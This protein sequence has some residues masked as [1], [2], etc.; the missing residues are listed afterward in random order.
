VTN[1]VRKGIVDPAAFAGNPDLLVYGMLAALVSAALWLH[2]ASYFGQPVSTTHSIVGAIFG[3]GLIAGGAINWAKMTAIVASWV[4]SPLASGL[5]GFLTFVFIKKKIL[6]TERPDEAAAKYAPYLV[7][8]VTFMLSMA[9]IFKGLK[10]LHLDWP[11]TKALVVSA[12]AAIGAGVLAF[13]LLPK[14]VKREEELEPT[15][16]F[17]YTERIFKYLQITTASY[18]A[19]AHGANDVA[20]AVGPLAAVYAV[21]STGEVT[22]KVGVPIW[23]LLLGGAGIVVGLAMFGRRVMETVGHRITHMTPTR[24]FSAEFAA[25]TTVLVCSKIGLPIST[26]HSL[27]GAVMGVG[28]ARGLAAL[29]LKTILTLSDLDTAVGRGSADRRAAFSQTRSQS[30]ADASPNGDGEIHVDASVNR[31]GDQFRRV[32]FGYAKVDATVGGADVE[33]SPVP[34]CTIEFDTQAAVRRAAAHVATDAGQANATVRGLEINVAVDFIDGNAT[35]Q[36][37]Q[38][39]VRF[40]GYHQLVADRPSPAA[41]PIGASR[42]DLAAVG[43]DLDLGRELAGRISRSFE[44]TDSGPQLNVLLVPSL[45]ADAPVR[46]GVHRN[47][48]AVGRQ[49][50]LTYFAVPLTPIVI[51]PFVVIQ[52]GPFLGRRLGNPHN[53]RYEQENRCEGHLGLELHDQASL[54]LR[55]T[56]VAARPRRLRLNRQYTGRR[57]AGQVV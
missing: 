8:V 35:V 10:N 12:L 34:T 49:R 37:L 51:A 54:G 23:I 56:W 38:R 21:Q 15:E 28:L 36:R 18:V 46:V 4:I 43:D 20:N 41:T 40:P 26:T 22:M 45:Y 47:D 44:N 2:L 53:Q 29:R 57:G 39:Q 42:K 48:I 33:T 31:A 7:M 55:R 1:T 14:P 30:L 17:D 6:A 19:F 27:V 3:F 52:D 9:L 16:E 5:L 25:A 50:N 32:V 24:G 11:V 13:V